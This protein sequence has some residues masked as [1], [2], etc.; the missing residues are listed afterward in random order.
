MNCISAAARP[1]QWAHGRQMHN[2]DRRVG[3]VT[4]DEIKKISRNLAKVP[5]A[6]EGGLFRA[7]ET[8]F[9]TSG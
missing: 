2:L 7:V 1:I 4:M 6:V 8:I 9:C 3:A 5:S